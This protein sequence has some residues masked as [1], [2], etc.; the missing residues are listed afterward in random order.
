MPELP[1]V[2]TFRRYM[3]ATSLHKTIKKV[4]VRSPE[5]LEGISA[6]RLKNGLKN[7]K[8]ED[9][10]RR[11]KYLAALL[12]GNGCLV[13]HFGMTG[14]LKY[15]KNA[16]NGPPHERLR[17][18]FANGYHLAYDCQRKLGLVTLVDDFDRFMEKKGLGSDALAPDLNFQTFKEKVTGRQASI[19]SLLMNQKVIAGIGNIYAD[20]IL[21]QAKVH[22]KT[23]TDTLSDKQLKRIF[24]ARKGVLK[25]AIAHKAD[26]QDLP[27][28]YIT[29]VRSA[30]EKCPKCRGQITKTTVSGRPTYYCPACQ[31]E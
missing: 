2:E 22:P 4:D 19:K 24:T 28:T 15:F 30:N 5:I 21:F 27:R 9:T 18:A 29:P 8:F 23:R 25:T 31:K 16:G 13:M 17:I 10:R 26:P 7:R 12:D 6:S 1:D 3:A 14:F 20:E 11:G